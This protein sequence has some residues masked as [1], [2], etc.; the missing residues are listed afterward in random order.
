[1][2]GRNILDGSMMN[3]QAPKDRAGPKA[4]RTAACSV[5]HYRRRCVLM[6]RRRSAAVRYLRLPDVRGL[7]VVRLLAHERVDS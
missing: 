6:T 7:G 4:M 2:S 1:M 5:M 3:D